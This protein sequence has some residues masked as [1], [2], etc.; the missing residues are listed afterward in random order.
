MSTRN[1]RAS[2]RNVARLLASWPIA[3]A[4]VRYK[5]FTTIFAQGDPC[6]A[7][8]F[9]ANGRV[10][11]TVTS[12]AGRKAVVGILGAGAFLGEGALAGQ[13]LRRTTAETL[14]GSTIM[15][16]KTAEMRR[17]LHE[18]SPLS[19]WFRSHLLTRNNSIEA[20]LLEHVFQRSEIRLARVLLLLA[21]VDERDATHYALPRI[22]RDLLAETIGTT[23]SRVDLLMKKFRKLGFLERHRGPNGGP[24]VHRSL[25]SVVL[26]D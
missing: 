4:S 23:R 13:R 14:T 5:P 12:P 7:V 20:A 3:T 26:E 24:H 21:R 25:L 16:V 2:A 8:M 19:R 18:Q 10:Q 15:I 6:A 11:L 17:R 9:I 22:T 1:T